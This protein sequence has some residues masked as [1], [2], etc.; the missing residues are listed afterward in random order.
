LHTDDFNGLDPSHHLSFLERLGVRADDEG[1][2][3]L[4]VNAGHLRT[5]G[6]VHGGVVATVLDSVMGM[7]AARL[8]P[9]D[10]YVVTAQ[11]NVHFIRPAWEGETLIASSKVRHHGRRTAVAEGEIKTGSDALV[12][13][14]SA[15][16]IYVPHTERTKGRS[17]PLGPT[18]LP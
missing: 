15:T 11:L 1:R 3:V 13:T 14:A 10:H 5:L 12:A 4:E 7:C 16:F 17:E 9:A 8:A 6:I 18:P 2:L